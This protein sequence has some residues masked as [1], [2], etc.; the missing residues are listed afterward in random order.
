MAEV[1]DRADPADP[2]RNAGAGLSIIV[3]LL[4]Q[5]ERGLGKAIAFVD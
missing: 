2:G 3:L 1:F 5:S 4:L